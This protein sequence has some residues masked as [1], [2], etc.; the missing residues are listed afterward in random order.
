MDHFIISYDICAPRTLMRAHRAM[1][2][3]GVPI[4]FSVFLLEGRPS[5]VRRCL[6]QLLPMLDSACDDV[7][8]YALPRRR[9]SRRCLGRAA[10]PD[11]IVYGGAPVSAMR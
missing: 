9:H 2:A 11:G 7:R 8:V 10:L 6:Q 4:Q 5:D 3:W 1:L